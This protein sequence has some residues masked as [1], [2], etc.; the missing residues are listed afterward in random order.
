MIRVVTLLALVLLAQSMDDGRS[1]TMAA[2]P[3]G[4]HV[5][6]HVDAHIDPR[7]GTPS[8]SPPERARRD[9]PPAPAVGTGVMQSPLPPATLPYRDPLY[10]D[11]R[12]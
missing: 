12:Y 4:A 10:R 7:E 9:S 5:D 11:R 6:R 2:D 3:R 8:A 1:R